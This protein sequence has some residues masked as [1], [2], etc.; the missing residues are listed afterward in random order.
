MND[1]Q[2]NT[3]KSDFSRNISLMIIVLAGIAAGLWYF[4]NKARN[5]EKNYHFFEVMSTIAE[6]TIYGDSKTAEKA[7]DK[8]EEVFKD[9]QNKCNAFDPKSE[10]SRLNATAFDAPFKCDDT[11]WE[12]LMLSK[13]YYKMS[14]GGFDITV[15]PLMELWGFHRKSN[16]IPSDEEVTET[17]K[18]VGLDKV[19]FDEKAHTVKFNVKGMKFDLGGIAKGLAV[20]KAASELREMGIKSGFINLAGNMYCFPLPPPGKKFY[21]IGV[22]NPFKMSETCGSVPL[23]NSSIATSGNYE[24][25]V[26][27]DDKR[28]AHIMNPVTGRPVSNSISVTVVSPRAMNTDGLSAAVFVKGPE[29]AKKI[30]ER[31]PATHILIIRYK[32]DNSGE[33]EILKFGSIWGE[34]S[35]PEISKK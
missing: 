12:L 28:Y 10:L 1:P 23:L 18:L 34:I 17:L 21:S 19:T 2:V 3:P 13:D 7:F 27:I 5:P 8:V 25:F 29:L 6:V 11:L 15:K 30:C 31:I 22:R 33:I 26:T 9:I 24:R 35:L 16:K 32:D 20:E 4:N 14:D